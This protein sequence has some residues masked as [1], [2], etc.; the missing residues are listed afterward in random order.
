MTG[1][2]GIGTDQTLTTCAVSKDGTNHRT[3][4]TCDNALW[5]AVATGIIAY[6]TIYKF[7]TNDAASIPLISI[8]LGSTV[9]ANGSNIGWTVNAA[10]IWYLQY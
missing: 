1:I 8:L 4:F 6:I 3:V 10:G 2:T 9:T 5:T 7:I